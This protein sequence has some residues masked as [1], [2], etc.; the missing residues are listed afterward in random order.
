M[1]HTCPDCCALGSQ[2]ISICEGAEEDESSD[3]KAVVAGW[4]AASCLDAAVAAAADAGVA[5]RWD[6]DCEGAGL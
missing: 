1:R 3:L 2:E 4:L 5:G 6:G